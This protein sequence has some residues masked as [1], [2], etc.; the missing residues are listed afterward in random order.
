MR[1]DR[2]AGGGIRA[3]A[4]AKINL[5]L[6]V[7]GV[8]PDGY[9]EIDTIMQEVSLHDEIEVRAR[10]G[11]GP[12]RGEIRLEVV[13]DDDLPLDIGPPEENLVWRAARRVLE[14][15]G[16]GEKAPRLEVRLRK[17]IP[18]G[19]GLGGGSSDAASTLAA[20]S[21]LLEAGLGVESLLEEAAK[22]GSDVPFF[23]HGGMA[24]CRGRGEIIV[25]LPGFPEESPLH[26]V[27]VYPGFQVPTSLI[28]K[29]LDRLEKVLPALTREAP[30]DTMSPQALPRA[31]QRGELFFNR[32]ERIACRAFPALE[33]YKKEI[34][35]EPFVATLLSGSGST[36]YG[37]AKSR[38]EAEE[39][40]ARLRER[41]PG[42]IFV[43]ESERG[44]TAPRGS[45]P[46]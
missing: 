28:Y 37:V 2:L 46:H 36:I 43:V 9:H 40:A 7:L 19:A 20:V 11:G 3:L 30:P 6:E 15:R 38:R 29:E 17:R 4:P 41:I 34:Q 1:M 44:T 31:F 18:L 24:R 16:P 10:P 14:R 8:R 13:G 23:I 25:P 35:K 32:L 42:K 22:L 33:S 27:L 12:G 26:C 21:N 45:A 5:H 39:M